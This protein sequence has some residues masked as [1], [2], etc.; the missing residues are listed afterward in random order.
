MKRVTLVVAAVATLAATAVV[1]P[2]RSVFDTQLRSKPHERG[3]SGR[4]G[5]LPQ[6][7]DQLAATVRLRQEYAA[8]RQIVVIDPH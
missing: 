5:Q 3:R 4:A 7:G 1:A 6:G 2:G 8:G